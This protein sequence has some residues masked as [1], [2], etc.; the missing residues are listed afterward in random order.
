MVRQPTCNPQSAQGS[1]SLQ[2]ASVR[3]PPQSTARPAETA[4]LL[5]AFGASGGGLNS[6]SA[7][8]PTERADGA[9][10]P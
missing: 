4:Q 6:P 2:S 1:S 10:L 3:S 5:E 7:S 9:K 8:L